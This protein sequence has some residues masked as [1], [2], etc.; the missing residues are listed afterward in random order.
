MTTERL[1]AVAPP[2][3]VPLAGD[4][5]AAAAAT[6]GAAVAADPS[7]AHSP[8]PATR[9]LRR[10]RVVFNAVK[11][12]FRQVEKRAGI[13]G[14]QVWALSIVAARPGIGVGAL[15][16]AMDIRQATSSNLVR[17]LV[18]GGWVAAERSGHDRRAVQLRIR[19]A[20]RALLRRAPGPS[21]GVLPEAL[22][23]LDPAT[24]ARLDADLARLIVL[25]HADPRAAAVPLAQM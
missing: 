5:A 7:D 19:P 22:A 15:A 25:L 2:A 20:G 12:H 3:A 17:A 10:F 8:D 23:R 14:A 4:D 24:L 13:G 18:A 21:S 1:A 11:T 16:R 6:A 9:V